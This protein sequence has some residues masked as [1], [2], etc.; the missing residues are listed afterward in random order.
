MGLHADDELFMGWGGELTLA[1]DFYFIMSNTRPG[2]SVR[3]LPQTHTHTRTHTHTHTDTQ[4]LE[5][6]TRAY[7][8]ALEM[9][10]H[11]HTHTRTHPVALDHTGSV[12][13]TAPPALPDP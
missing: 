7:T 8:H 11:V 12:V 6:H 13:S 9:H 2:L 5:M 10:T 4:A 1:E 3:T